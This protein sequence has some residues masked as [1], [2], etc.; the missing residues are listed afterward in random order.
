MIF[1]SRGYFVER[2]KQANTKPEKLENIVADNSLVIILTWS[3]NIKRSTL[4]RR[5]KQKAKKLGKNI[6]IVCQ[7]V[8]S[9]LS[10]L[11]MFFSYPNNYAYNCSYFLITQKVSVNYTVTEN[12]V[13]WFPFFITYSC[14]YYAM[15]WN[16]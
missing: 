1:I 4:L 15:E 5:E 7:W 16:E 13:S 9:H 12:H 11:L 6:P 14:K 8:M 10:K 2:S 3:G